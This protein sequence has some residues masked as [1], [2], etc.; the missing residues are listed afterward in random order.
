MIEVAQA[1][2]AYFKETG[3]Y[4]PICSDGGIV[5]DYH[6]TLALAMGADFIMLGRYFARFD[7]SPTNKVNI[8]GSSIP[9]NTG[10]KVLSRARNWQRY[11]MGGDAKLSFEE[12]V[13][14]YVPYAGSLHDNVSL[15]LKKVKSTMCNCGV[16]VY[17]RNCRKKQ[18]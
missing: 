5:Y 2:D 1:R 4:I 11:D 9:K 16:F 15:S 8:N 12:G 6:M 7:E 18:N 14:S 13:D 3:I 17:F 10:V